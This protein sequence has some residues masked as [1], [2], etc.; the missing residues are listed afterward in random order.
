MYISSSG[1]NFIN[2]VKI[3]IKNAEMFILALRATLKHGFV[4]KLMGI[5]VCA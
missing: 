1:L 4:P 3:T 5:L 2:V